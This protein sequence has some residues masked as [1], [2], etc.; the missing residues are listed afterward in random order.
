[1]HSVQLIIPTLPLTFGRRELL[2]A[3]PLCSPSQRVAQVKRE[4]ESRWSPI[5][6][7]SE[8]HARPSRPHPDRLLYRPQHQPAHGPRRSCHRGLCPPA[9]LNRE[10]D[11]MHSVEQ[12]IRIRRSSS[13]VLPRHIQT[14]LEI[15]VTLLRK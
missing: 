14:R 4:S 6:L 7:P 9:A 3:A 1:T 2:L 5:S 15:G 10:R 8:A 11:R 13:K 12:V